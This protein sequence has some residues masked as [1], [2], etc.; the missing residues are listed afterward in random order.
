LKR[1]HANQLR[2][3]V[4]ASLN[5]EQVCGGRQTLPCLPIE[6][7]L[8]R[9]RTS[10]G[11]QILLLGRSLGCLRTLFGRHRFAVFGV[12]TIIRG[13]ILENGSTLLFPLWL[14]L[15]LQR[16]TEASLD[17]FGGTSMQWLADQ[18]TVVPE[19]QQHLLTQDDLKK[20]F[21]F[22]LQ[23]G[24][25]SALCLTKLNSTFLALLGGELRHLVLVII[26]LAKPKSSAFD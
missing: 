6:L 24:A 7:L 14:A 23:S 25:A 10:S 16:M 21:R 4:L 18:V 12:F 9:D 17:Q 5:L 1:F 2:L 11:K 22:L 15:K 20:T 19:S 13:Q 3:A 8:F 26:Y